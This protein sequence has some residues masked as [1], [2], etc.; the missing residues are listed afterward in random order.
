MRRRSQRRPEQHDHPDDH[1]IVER[2][3]VHD[4]R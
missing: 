4:T 2:R 3:A 1:A